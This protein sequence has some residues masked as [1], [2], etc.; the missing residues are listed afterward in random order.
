LLEPAETHIDFAAKAADIVNLVRAMSPEPGAVCLDA[1]GS[2]LKVFRASLGSG[3]W[4]DAEPG[5]V[6]SVGKEGF[7]VVAGDG[8]SVVIHEVQPEG[9]RVMSVSEYLA[10]HHVEVGGKLTKIE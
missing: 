5:T 1:Q 6:V 3:Q 2:R 7:E 8:G 10:G 9:R 4:P